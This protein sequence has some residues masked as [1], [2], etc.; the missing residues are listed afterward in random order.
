MWPEDL[1]YKIIKNFVVNAGRSINKK[2]VKRAIKFHPK[3]LQDE[4]ET[5]EDDE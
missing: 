3:K 5:N 4:F 1:P 2:R